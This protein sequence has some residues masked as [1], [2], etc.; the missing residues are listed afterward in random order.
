MG[1]Q[2]EEMRKEKRR[3]KGSSSDA[4]PTLVGSSIYIGLVTDPKGHLENAHCAR[5]HRAATRREER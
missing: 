3:S 1:R 2:R 4:V 5:K